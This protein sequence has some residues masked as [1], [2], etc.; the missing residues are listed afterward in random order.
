MRALA[1]LLFFAPA[2]VFA[3]GS[4]PLVD[5]RVEL[6]PPPGFVDL[7]APASQPASQPAEGA[8]RL[9]V[10]PTGELLSARV[11]TRRMLPVLADLDRYDRELPRWLGMA[12]G[13]TGAK[14]LRSKLRS[15]GGISSYEGWFTADVQGHRAGAALVVPLD[16][17]ALVLILLGRVGSDREE[18]RGAW[19]ETLVRVRVKQRRSG[20]PATAFRD[21]ATGVTLRP[22]QGFQDL[23]DLAAAPE[24]GAA[25]RKA[26]WVRYGLLSHQALSVAQLTG[27]AAKAAREQ[28]RAAD[29]KAPVMVEQVTKMPVPP[30]GQGG[31]LPFAL[32]GQTTLLLYQA[33]P[34]GKLSL[35]ALLPAGKERML[36]LVYVA[37][38]EDFADQLPAFAALCAQVTPP[39]T[40]VWPFAAAGAGAVLLALVIVQRKRKAVPAM[41]PQRPE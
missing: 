11:T 28:L 40:P 30:E 32:G 1:A 41:P 24:T 8:P 31:A 38:R 4:S 15:L 6:T 20:A 3:A 39:R 13:A 25:E 33:L 14:A 26:A 37:S 12:A 16:D 22:A 35:S 29:G 18:L 36:V 5:R 23:V 21:E 10:R 7:P 34:G 17:G 19:E 9:W 2:L 27:A